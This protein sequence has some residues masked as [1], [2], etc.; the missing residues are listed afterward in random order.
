MS[1]ALRL[2]GSVF[3]IILAL[4][5]V[6]ADTPVSV[7]PAIDFASHFPWLVWV[8]SEGHDSEY[9]SGFRYKLISV[10]TADSSTVEFALVRQLTDGTKIV[11]IHAKGPLSKFD[12]SST[13]LLETMSRSVNVTFQRFDL[14]DVRDLAGLNNKI[15]EYG[16]DASELPK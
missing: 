2:V 8:S 4:R 3:A 10:R 1:I 6:Q 16:W 5:P 14:R 7:L 9:P 11:A 12:E 15:R 13:R